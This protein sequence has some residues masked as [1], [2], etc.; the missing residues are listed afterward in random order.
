MKTAKCDE[1]IDINRNIAN[2]KSATATIQLF[3][4]CSTI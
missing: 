2:F 4:L 3:N 1:I